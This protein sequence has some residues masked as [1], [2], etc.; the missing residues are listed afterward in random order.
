MKKVAN[1][2]VVTS[3][4][5]SCLNRDDMGMQKSL[6][7]GGVRR[8]MISSQCQKY[9]WRNSDYYRE[10]L[11][12]P[13]M[14]TRELGE[15]LEF[16]VEQLK[17]RFE[18]AIVERAISL[19][20]G[21]GDI[22]TDTRGDAVAPWAIEE[23]AYICEQIQS[24]ECKG[25][26]D[27]KLQQHINKCSQGFRQAIGQTV[28]IALSGRMAT[29][30][31]M[32][33]SG[34]FDGALS[35]GFAFSTHAANVDVDWF[36]A[37]DDFKELGAGHLDSQEFSASVYYK[38]G[39]INIPQLQ[40]NLGNA[41][42]EEALKIVAHVLHMMATQTPSGKQHSFAAY[43]MAEM[44]M[45]SFSDQELSL[46]NAFET[47]IRENGAGLRIPSINALN[48]HHQRVTTKHGL[49]CRCAE[50][51]VEDL[52]TPDGILVVPSLPALE[53]WIRND[54]ANQQ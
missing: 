35:V 25:L 18:S 19:I 20:S 23:I 42:R 40:K 21:K 17:D 29:D 53:Q 31:L 33:T 30:G 39:S 16:A 43:E 6:I 2:H 45:V 5:S 26:D 12:N 49:D 44:A 22:K 7:F 28:D 1:F 48:D 8:A 27:K 38:H 52:E 46:A 50:F 36:A 10:H 3:N 41:S 37:T 11:G 32:S 24:S 51:M 14:R 54:G 47:P 34:Q 15:L 13:S 4:S 9:T